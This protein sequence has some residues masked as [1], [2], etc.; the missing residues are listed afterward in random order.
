M[1]LQLPAGDGGHLLHKVAQISCNLIVRPVWTPLQPRTP[2]GLLHMTPRR[3]R[4][5]SALWRGIPSR[6]RRG[7][8][9]EGDGARRQARL[10]LI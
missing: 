6:E 8:R 10:I 7:R 4:S 9:A 1:P 5:T 2:Q 3:A